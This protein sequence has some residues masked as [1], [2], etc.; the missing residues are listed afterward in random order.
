MLDYSKIKPFVYIIV[1]KDLNPRQIV[2]QS[3][4]AALESGI[5]QEHCKDFPSGLIMLQ[6]SNEKSL[7]RAK[8]KL[9]KDG[10][11]SQLFWERPMERYTSLATEAI[12]QDKRYLMK[13]FQLLSM[14]RPT[15]WQKLRRI[16]NG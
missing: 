9:D 11:K 5:H 16:F 7:L 4:H 3:C 2:V 6:V 10:I 12:P 14:H 8:R 15:W 13:K 1:C